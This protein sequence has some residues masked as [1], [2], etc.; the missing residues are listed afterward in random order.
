MCE[1]I[2]GSIP[3]ALCV[4]CTWT[5]LH[6]STLSLLLSPRPGPP[7]VHPTYVLEFELCISKH[8]ITYI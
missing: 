4:L 5:L 7:T 1:D 8:Q 2:A 3:C 6:V